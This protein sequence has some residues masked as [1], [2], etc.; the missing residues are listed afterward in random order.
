MHVLKNIL[1]RSVAFVA[2]TAALAQTVTIGTPTS[3]A[4]GGATTV[5]IP[6]LV[7]TP[8]AAAATTST[9]NLAIFDA[10]VGVSDGATTVQMLGPSFTTIVLPTVLKDSANAWNKTTNKYVAPVT[11]SYRVV[12]RMRLVD[13]VMANSSVGQGANTV[14]ADGPYLLWTTNVGLRNSSVNYR[15]VQ[16]QKGD[17]I[18]FFSYLDIP[19]GGRLN[20]A[21]L[22]IEQV[23]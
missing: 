6:V 13:G 22:M 14:N 16:L 1:F 21:E 23:Q 9:S 10:T 18:S 7:S 17:A 4:T 2:A 11:G 8:A 15:L 3:A 5:T 20:S 12:T 19:A